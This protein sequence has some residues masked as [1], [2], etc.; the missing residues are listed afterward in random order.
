[1]LS[2]REAEYLTLV[3]VLI[4]QG[5]AE[6]AKPLLASLKQSAESSQCHG[7]LI[8]ILVVE[9]T[10]QQACNAGEAAL[11]TLK[12]AL[13]LAEPAEYLRVFVD[14]TEHSEE[15]KN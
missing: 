8:E 2:W 1:M 13:T 4:A 7:N 14:V 9:A 3:R 10:A 15:Q 12:Q 6:Q 5:Q 11:A